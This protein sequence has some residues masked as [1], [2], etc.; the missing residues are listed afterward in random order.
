M[1]APPR[2]GREGGTATAATA[3]AGSEPDSGH[4]EDRAAR[5]VWCGGIPTTM[6]TEQALRAVLRKAGELESVNVRTKEGTNRSWALVTFR[7]AK[8]VASI[9]SERERVRQGLGAT[10]GW[11]ILPVQV[12]K[13]RSLEA[14]FALAGT[15]LAHARPIPPGGSS[16]SPNS[17]ASPRNGRIQRQLLTYQQEQQSLQREHE[18]EGQRAPSDAGGLAGPVSASEASEA[19]AA[20][21]AAEQSMTELRRRTCTYLEVQQ[22][23][24]AS[25]EGTGS[26]KRPPSDHKHNFK[27]AVRWAQ[28]QDVFSGLG[29]RAIRRILQGGSLKTVPP[30]GSAIIKKGAPLRQLMVLISGSASTEVTPPPSEEV[31]DP[32][33]FHVG[34]V[35]SLCLGSRL[36]TCTPQ[37]CVPAL[38][39]SCAFALRG[40]TLSQAVAWSGCR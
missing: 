12:Q 39:C 40:T 9:T 2:G 30:G 8:H 15:E 1:A 4:A 5:T 36:T 10:A 3:D 19:A 24:R 29:E 11:R 31:G 20:A 22:R 25:S 26:S 13:L 28:R 35:A 7:S 6:A 17:S 27:Q 18:I 14:Q 33:L 21:A 16:S 23:L 32:L 37:I 38:L 34:I